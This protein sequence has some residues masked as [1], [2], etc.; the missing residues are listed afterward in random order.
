MLSVLRSLCY[1]YYS[2]CVI[3]I[4]VPA[5]A[6][7]VPVSSVPRYPYQNS[8]FTSAQLS[9]HTLR[10]KCTSVP[11]YRFI[12]H[13]LPVSQPPAI[14]A[15]TSRYL[16]LGPPRC[17]HLTL[18]I[19]QSPTVDSYTPCY[20]YLSLQLSVHAPYVTY[21][22]VPPPPYWCMHPILPIS[23]SPPIRA[24]T[25]VTCIS[26]PQLLVHTAHVTRHVTFILVPPLSVLYSPFYPYHSVTLKLPFYLYPAISDL[27]DSPSVVNQYFLYCPWCGFGMLIAVTVL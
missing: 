18:L 7:I 27:S 3:C 15:Y 21:I 12:H 1:P 5:I 19:S 16:Y 25:Q 14:G 22:S 17:I 23:Q 11:R 26:A 2:P 10:I 9:V 13:L 6:V 8:S 24:Y 4:S 20:M